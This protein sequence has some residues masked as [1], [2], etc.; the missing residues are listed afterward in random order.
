M[1]EG[2][3]K[4]VGLWWAVAYGVGTIL[5]AGIYALIGVATGKAGNLVWLSFALA[6]GIA[7][8]SGLSYAKLSSI[9]PS[10]GAEY[11]YVESAFRSKFWAFVVGWLVLISS[12]ISA[13]T[14]AQGF[15]GYLYSIFDIPV[16]VGASAL[17]V[18]LAIVNY[19]GI[20]ESLI[21]N[22]IMTIVEMIGI[23]I[24]IFLGVGYLGTVDYTQ[25]PLGLE[26]VV[27]AVGIIFFAFIGFEGL[28][29][30]G[31]ETKDAERT[32]PRALM[33]SLA[34]T[35]VLYVLVAISV[36]SIVPFDELAASTSPLADVALQASGQEAFALL[37]L[38]ALVA[39]ANTVLIILI[40]SSRIAYGMSTRSALPKLLSRIQPSTGTPLMAIALT[41]LASVAFCFLGGIEL[42]ANVSNFTIFMVFLAVNLSVIQLSR[43]SQSIGR[44]Y[45][46]AAVVGSLTSV[47]MLTQ[48]SWEVTL[49][50]ILLTLSGAGL[51]KIMEMDLR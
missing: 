50:S 26:G 1:A 44:A 18:V 49:L 27:G 24:V 32:I 16:A 46:L 10:S 17:I 35:A 13:A 29:K 15:G 12:I 28:V 5:G 8:F 7:A 34:I 43:G 3:R 6:A 9:Y 30:I 20:K 36:V 47:A 22:A 31:D 37:T 45:V 48:F 39:T 14:V 33:L 38:I 40:A 51:Y 2:L 11:V 23:L 4:E 25:S 41:T 21:L 42:T 19:A